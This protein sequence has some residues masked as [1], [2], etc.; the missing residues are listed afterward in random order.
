MNIELIAEPL[1]ITESPAGEDLEA[2]DQAGDSQSQAAIVRV[3]VADRV[4]GFEQHKQ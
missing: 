1:L 4:G 2:M 3:T